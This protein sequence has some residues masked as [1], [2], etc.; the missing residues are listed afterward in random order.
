MCNFALWIVGGHVPMIS[1]KPIAASTLQLIGLFKVIGDMAK[2]K[3][4]EEFIADAIKKHG[5]KYDY[6]LIKEY[7]NSKTKVPIKCN[8]CGKVF[9][10][11]PN[12]HLNGRNCSHCWN[13]NRPQFSKRKI[14]FGRAILD[15]DFS[16]NQNKE[17][18]CLYKTWKNMF[19]RCY[20]NSDKFKPY[21]DCTVCDEWCNFSSF[22]NWCLCNGFKV[23]YQLDKD[24]L[25]K[26]E[27]CL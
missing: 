6:S 19:E 9:W 15:V 12:D 26:G 22:Y 20:S 7:V 25:A 8:R 23:G 14:L 5:D 13:Y 24:I 17:T 4:L 27:S 3:T 2:K 1:G 18:S 21:L 16:I 10:Q 11:K